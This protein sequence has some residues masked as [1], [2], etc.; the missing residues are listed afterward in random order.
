MNIEAFVDVLSANATVPS[1]SDT[2][3]AMEVT[4]DEILVGAKQL[5]LKIAEY[6]SVVLE[7]RNRD[8]FGG[9]YTK[10]DKSPVTGLDLYVSERAESDLPVI[11]PGPVLTEENIADV[12]SESSDPAVVRWIV[13]PIDGTKGLK[14]S[15]SL[16]LE[17]SGWGISAGYVV[18]D[19]PVVGALGIPRMGR[20]FVGIIGHG[21]YEYDMNTQEFNPEPLLSV[22]EPSRGRLAAVPSSY[23]GTQWKRTLEL[24]RLNGFEESDLRHVS[25]VV[26]LAQLVQGKYDAAGGVRGISTWDL[27]GGIPFVRAAGGEVYDVDTGRPILLTPGKEKQELSGYIAVRQGQGFVF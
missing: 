10:A 19:V 26:K 23:R 9:T 1:L 14:R 21:S 22:P 3:P 16:P 18:G 4:T 8:D 13:D 17:R 27:A 5:V 7:R 25:S 24:F 6:G 2:F 11:L 15:Q 12:L 20:V